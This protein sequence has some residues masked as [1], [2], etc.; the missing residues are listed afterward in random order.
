[1]GLRGT[2]TT[3]LSSSVD[4]QNELL[5]IASIIIFTTDPGT[6]TKNITSLDD[7]DN[8]GTV[9]TCWSLNYSSYSPCNSE[10]SMISNITIATAPTTSIGHTPSKEVE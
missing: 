2:T 9:Y 4:S 7:I 6:P 1:M 3:S 10:I 8:E 5:L